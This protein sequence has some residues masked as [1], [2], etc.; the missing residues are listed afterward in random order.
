VEYPCLGLTG[1]RLSRIILGGATFGE[2]NSPAEVARLI[3]AAV[4]AGVTTVDTGDA[5]AQGHSEE[6]IGR[7]ISSRRDR[8]VICTKVGLRVGDGVQDHAITVRNDLDYARRWSAG[9]SP[10]DQGLSRAHI[11][12]A[13][14]A[15]LRRLRTDYI[16]LYQLHY[17]DPSASAGETLLA[18]EDLVRAGKVRYVGCSNLQPTQLQAYL[19]ASADLPRARP[20]CMQVGY[21]AVTRQAESEV[22]P[23]CARSR[24]SALAIMTLAGGLLTGSYRRDVEPPPGSRLAA[25]PMYRDR[26]WNDGTFKVVKSFERLASES[27]RTVSQVALGWVLANASITA[28]VVGAERPEHLEDFVKVADQ[29]L[30]EGELRQLQESL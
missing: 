24:V 6:L 13:V 27:G 1:F 12:G 25:R 14:D 10:N 7:A 5:Y 11:M 22:L 28:A 21:N 30:T 17:W 9:I 19:D 8:L 3:D 26:F 29:P 2:L 15:S 23:F 4:D 18:L 20:Q 16:D